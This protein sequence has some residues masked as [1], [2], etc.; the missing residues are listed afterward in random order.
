MLTVPC[1]VFTVP[2]VDLSSYTQSFPC[3]VWLQI[4]AQ[5][6]Q[7]VLSHSR[8]RWATAQLLDWFKYWIVFEL[9]DR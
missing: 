5:G 2:V 7:R 8:G 9:G 6:K 4:D 3:G 1:S